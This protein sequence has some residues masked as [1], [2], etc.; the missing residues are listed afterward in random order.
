MTFPLWI[1]VGA[2]RA[3]PH[4]V[5]E[6][7]AY[8]AA[9]AAYRHVRSRHED[10]VSVPDRWSLAAAAIVGAVAGSRFLFWLED[11]QRTLEQLTNIQY[12]VGGQTI[13]G[14]VIGGWIAVEWQ[15]RRLGIHAPTGDVF[16]IPLALGIAVGRIG[17]FLSGIPDGT[18]GIATTLP[19]GIDLG[20]GIARHPTALYESAFMFGVA[21]C[22]SK[23]RRSAARGEVFLALIVAYLA[24]RVAVEFLKPGVA[25][26]AGMTAIQWAAVAGLFMSFRT[27]RARR[28][29]ESPGVAVETG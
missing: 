5:F 17:C 12:L 10:D 28:V 19:W 6:L 24:F 2:W 29:A 22:L 23:L 9:V 11:P 26:A 25:L 20:D 18:Y 15:K 16:A 1:R 13:V 27:W 21:W 7:L 3:H 4:F 8:S 14:G